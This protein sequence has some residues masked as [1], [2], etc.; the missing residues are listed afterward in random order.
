MH[1]GTIWRLQDG[2]AVSR[3]LGDLHFRSGGLTAEPEISPWRVVGRHDDT[4]LVLVS[5]GVTETLSARHICQIAAATVSGALHRAWP[6]SDHPLESSDDEVAAVINGYPSM[7][8]VCHFHVDCSGLEHREP[9]R[10]ISTDILLKSSAMAISVWQTLTPQCVRLAFR[11]GSSH[12]GYAHGHPS[13]TTPYSGSC[14]CTVGACHAG[15]RRQCFCVP[16]GETCSARPVSRGQRASGQQ[17]CS[18][19]SSA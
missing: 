12:S 8:L 18:T 17:K 16:W 3:A 19:G 2:L 9:I 14:S 1:T 10:C 15:G 4:F 7:I 6:A 5:D 11:G 13:A